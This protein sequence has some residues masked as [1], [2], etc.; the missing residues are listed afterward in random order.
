MVKL[1]LLLPA[2]ALVAGSILLQ[3]QVDTVH[4]QVD[5]LPVFALTTATHRAGIS[6]VE[7]NDPYLSSLPYSGMG[8]RVELQEQ[9]YLRAGDNRF[10]MVNRLTGLAAIT[11]NPASTAQ[12]ET[13]AGAYAFGIRYHY[14]PLDQL[15]I[16]AGG[17]VEGDFG[18]RANSRNVNNPVNMDI[19]ANLNATVGARYLLPLR[20]RTLQF[21]AQ[22]EI[23]LVG[24][25]FVPY[26][27]LSYYELYLSK[28][29]SE[30]IFVSSL[31][32]RQGGKLAFSVDVPFR[33]STLHVGWRY[34]QLHYQGN[35]PVF[36]LAEHSVL[37]GISYDLFRSAGRSSRF[38]ATYVR[39]R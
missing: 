30:A 8:F 19:A 37:L 35:G 29:L 39:V 34:H 20:R 36:T 10:S 21:D 11:T 22:A 15:V 13:I 6:W 12:I 16:L 24:V 2:I 23:P 4:A 31:H 38:P 33:R 14:R 1:R 25:M 7:L 27:G 17:A 28:Q 5:T 9:R 18:V 3:A 32:N 26:P